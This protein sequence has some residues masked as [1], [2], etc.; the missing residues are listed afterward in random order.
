MARSRRSAS[1]VLGVA[2]LA[3]GLV[4]CGS[5]SGSSPLEDQGLVATTSAAPAPAWTPWPQALHDA[6]HSGTSTSVGPRTGRLRWQRTL[7]GN[8][9]PGPV[10]GRDGTIYAASNAG[11]LHA[12]DPKDGRDRW[13]VDEHGSYGI[14][15]ST[16]PAV[17]TGG[18]ILWP[19]PNGNLVAVSP[20]GTVLWRL[21]VGGQVT[22]PAVR[23]DGTVVVGN[24]RGLLLGLEPTSTGPGE[25]WRLD[26]AEQSYGSPVISPDGTTAYQSV[27]SGVVAVRD[28]SVV[29]RWQVPS[30]I[31]EVSPAVAP[32]GTVVI[33]TND[34]YQ[35]G[36]DPGDG[37]VRWRYRRDA[38]TYSS[39]GVTGDGI[40]YF[41][42]HGNRIVGVD[43]DTGEVRFRHQG[44][45]TEESPGDIAIWTAI[46]VDRDHTTYAGT[47]QGRVYAVASDGTELWS[48]HAGSTVDSYP[49]LTGDGALVIGT[50]GG[51]LLAF[52]D[53]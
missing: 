21:A 25:V 32:S 12:L 3:L 31:V 16:S 20:S 37:S 34:P 30:E 14:D 33:G 39:P 27:L 38:W 47:R 24:N 23:A 1:P 18:E 28:G 45:T 22:S 52:A 51:K 13:T 8:V 17:L 19:G 6:Q 29:W 41:G 43:A 4:A 46:A 42:D 15:Q 53:R 9:T 49:A 50:A 40:A 35:Y 7:E 11:V 48:Y 36:L 44:P 10:I 2:A 5:P 26:L